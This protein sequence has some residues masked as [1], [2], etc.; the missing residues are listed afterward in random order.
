MAEADDSSASF[1]V[2]VRREPGNGW[3][4]AIE[5]VSSGVRVAFS[6][7]EDIAPL[8]LRMVDGDGRPAAPH[9]G[10]DEGKVH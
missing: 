7:L 9:G 5:D 6:G 3:R 10:H 2:R 4:G 1:I 8:V